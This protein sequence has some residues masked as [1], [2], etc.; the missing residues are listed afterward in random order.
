MK[1]DGNELSLAEE[2]FHNNEVK[3][4]RIASFALLFTGILYIMVAAF[5][6]FTEDTGGKT[7]QAILLT[8][9]VISVLMFIHAAVFNFD[10][11]GIKDIILVGIIICSGAV[12]FLY[13]LNVTFLEFGPIVIAALYYDSGFVKRTA[14]ISWLVYSIMLWGN[15]VFDALSPSLKTFHNFMGITLF[16]YPLD[17]LTSR[18]IPHTLTFVLTSAICF[19]ITSR[20]KDYVKIRAHMDFENAKMEAELKAAEEIQK[21]S[22]PE[23]EL[24][25]GRG[26]LSAYVKTARNVGGDFYDYFRAGDELIFLVADVS[27]KGMGAAMYSTKVKSA[28]RLAVSC[29]SGLEEALQRANNLLCEDNPGNMFV[30]LF[31]VKINPF[32]GEG[33][34]V[35]CGH[36]PPFLLKAEG[37]IAA[38]EFEPNLILGV[39]PDIDFSSHSLSLSPSDK[40]FV[41]TDGITDAVNKNNES[42]GCERLAE[43]LKS[44]PGQPEELV[45]EVLKAVNEFAGAADQFDDMTVLCFGIEEA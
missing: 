34:F 33:S 11:P 4:N 1:S 42:F 28:V 26:V 21:A 31:A 16:E 15:V 19:K 30:T 44:A 3:T 18:Y 23:P 2:L 6:R 14:V 37:S 40:I 24:I 29:S 36:N 22:L 17:V 43:T 32:T 27:D 39:F 9:G 20:G 41:Y 45:E 35:N 8:F 7:A 38:L 25:C 13:P 10:E 5:D 12:F